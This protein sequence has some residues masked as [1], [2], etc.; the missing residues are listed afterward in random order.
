MSLPER[1]GRYL[2]L[3]RLGSGGMGDV[4]LAR[5]LSNGEGLP[6]ALVLKRLHAELAGETAFVQRFSHEAR[7]A[8]RI[9]SANVVRVYD[10]GCV[11]DVLYI[12]MELI[13]GWSVAHVVEETAKHG[14]TISLP[15]IADLAAGA[16]SGLHAL[17]TAIEDDGG[18]LAIVH[19]DIAPKNIMIGRDGRA[20]LIDLGIGKSRLKEW[21]T[22]TGAVLGSPGYMSPEQVQAFDVDHRSDLFSMG[23]V[24]YELL[25]LERAIPRGPLAQMLRASA[26]P[27][28]PPPSRARPDAAALD[29]IVARALALDPGER[30]QS[31]AE[32]I[33]A[34]RAA[35]AVPEGTM[36]TLLGEMIGREP[37]W[38]RLPLA[39]AEP[40]P[41]P[42]PRMVVFARRA[43]VSLASGAFDPTYVPALEVR[44]PGQRRSA[45]R[46]ALFGIAMA[47]L[48]AGATLIATRTPVGEEQPAT[49]APSE[50]APRITAEPAKVVV[51]PRRVEP[52][53]ADRPPRKAPIPPRLPPAPA[54]P[55]AV[56]A[57]ALH[58]AAEPV[59]DV[60]SMAAVDDERRRV[61]ERVR[62]LHW[63]LD[64]EEGS[65][66]I[67]EWLRELRD[68][69]IGTARIHEID[70]KAI[71]LWS[72]MDGVR[73][74]PVRKQPL[75]IRA[76][77][78]EPL[79]LER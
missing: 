10:A 58:P 49:L 41:G 48:G 29:P 61:L 66:V 26:R 19:R 30:F 47:G 45:V 22:R 34:I 36:N 74:Q 37:R 40:P 78:E 13:E 70:A 60:T 54:P 28:V 76:K 11:D 46:T 4:F 17:H 8:A 20:C 9:E 15:S 68:R 2:L 14:R 63:L 57:E 50:P 59:L 1:F 27:E 69:D 38:P 42:E 43:G 39:D 5:P 24:L 16:L 71:E 33:A 6:K 32:M 73:K 51:E 72:S 62:N 7:I 52:P 56:E 21:K 44:R 77:D 65:W 23:L 31:A 53:R 35:V 64:G 18:S 67:E 55:P 3:E 25:T 12:A 75:P 79:E